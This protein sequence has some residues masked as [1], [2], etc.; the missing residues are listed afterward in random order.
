MTAAL[1]G[2]EWSASRPGRNLPPGKTRYPFYRTLGGSQGRSRRAENL[3]PTGIR[4]RTVQ[5]LVSHYTDWATGPTPRIYKFQFQKQSFFGQLI[6]HLSSWWKS[7][8]YFSKFMNRVRLTLTD[9]I[10]GNYGETIGN[11]KIDRYYL[12]PLLHRA[13]CRVTQLSYQP[14]HIYKKFTH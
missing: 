10:L 8:H 14:L 13:C 2:G 11:L 12:F 5:P 6:M 9:Q 1:E 4:S 7:S 3:V